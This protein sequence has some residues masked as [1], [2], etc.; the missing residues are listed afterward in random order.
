MKL[1]PLLKDPCAVL[2]VRQPVPTAPAQHDFERIGAEALAAAQLEMDGENVVFKPNV[3]AGEHFANPESG[4]G[5]HP[6]FVGGMIGYVHQ[7]GARRDGVYIVEDPRNSDDNQPRHWK[8]TG[9]VE[10]AAATGAKLRTPNAYNCTLR[11]VPKPQAHATRRVSRLAVASNTVL[12]NVPKLKT[13]NLGITTLCMKN[14]M[15][16]DL[17]FDRHYCGQAWRDMPSHIRD[18]QRPRH[19]WMPRQIHEQ[20]QEGLARRLADL[21]Q[22]VQ[23]HLNVVEGVVGRDGTGFNRGRNFALGLAVVGVNVVAV[24]AVTSFIMGFDPLKLIYLNVAASVGL[25]CN[26]VRDLRVYT[27]QDGDLDVCHDIDR[28]RLDPAFTVITGVKDE[29]LGAVM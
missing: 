6:G 5:T 18:D 9:Y 16:L 21:A 27:A 20:W 14:L 23:P 28:L 12:I 3:T 11:T 29:Q 22:V 19:E 2:V 10:L 15:G 1:H 13:H 26:D 4:I 24:D 25:G 8:G 7:H 17:V